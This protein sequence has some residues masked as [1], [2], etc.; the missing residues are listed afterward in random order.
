MTTTSA[1]ERTFDVPR[2]LPWVGIVASLLGLWST[3]PPIM[4]RTAIPAIVLCL[5]GLAIGIV[6][7]RGGVKTQGWW[8]VTAAVLC[9]LIALRAT[10]ADP[11][12]LKK[13]MTA[14]LL[15]AMLR[16]ATP[17]TLAALGGLFSERAGVVN[18]GLEGTMLFGAFFG[19]LVADKSGSWVMG[20]VGALVTGALVGLLHG[21]FCI[22][23]QA[24]QIVVGT[25]I[26][27]LA[28]GA[29]AFVFRA[30]YG[31]DGSP[32]NISQVPNVS[33][34]GIRDIPFVGA[35]IGDLNLMVWLTFALVALSWWV[36]WR[37][38]IGLRIRAVGEHPRA[39]ETVGINVY[40]VRYLA[41][42]IS[43]MLAALGGA[44]LSIAFVGGF[45]ENMTNGRGF[46]ALAVMIL[47]KWKPVPILGSA[48]VFG[49]ASALAD[50]IEG[51][52]PDL[53]KSLPYVVTLVALVGFIGRAT[54]PAAD[55]KPYARGGH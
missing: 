18:I 25:G 39:A 3:L 35:V 20:L 37:T 17:L 23:L 6:A 2:W 19:M 40:A 27:I 46:I 28:L 44:Y 5:A 54:P 41:V 42:M 55:G 49:L 15:A 10:E 8:S 45:T 47:G 24:D 34:P 12:S 16:F 30:V 31:F 38:P 21:L 4:L 29:T 33:L 11:D 14:G 7:I 52:S 22:H 50:R 43:G 53:L 32:P 13:I 9:G 36:L 26:N 48:M 51:V 1:T